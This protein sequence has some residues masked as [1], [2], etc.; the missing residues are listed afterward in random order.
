MTQQLNYIKCK[1]KHVGIHVWTA[2]QQLAKWWW[3]IMTVSI[4]NNFSNFP[5][6]ANLHLTCEWLAD[7]P[8]N[9]NSHSLHMISLKDSQ[10]GRRARSAC[11]ILP[12]FWSLPNRGYCVKAT[13]N[14]FPVLLGFACF[15]VYS[16]IKMERIRIIL[17]CNKWTK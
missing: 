13:Y 2:Q 11:P 12:T 7:T 16:G 14:F 6:L 3:Q 1:L 4:L 9:Q 10:N 8:S 17:S 15:L 5:L